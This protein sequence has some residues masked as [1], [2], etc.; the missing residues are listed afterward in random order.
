[1]RRCGAENALFPDREKQPSL[2]HGKQ[3]LSLTR[4]KGTQ[5]PDNPSPK[6]GVP[7]TAKK[8]STAV[9]MG[10]AGA[11]VPASDPLAEFIVDEETL[12]E[13][14]EELALLPVPADPF[15]PDG[16]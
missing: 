14:E 13:L 11:L 7:I 1:M 4:V 9:W 8:A 15:A 2:I 3:R 5:S 10:T 6:S 16:M 12:E